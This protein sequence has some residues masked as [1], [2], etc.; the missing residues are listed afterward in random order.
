MEVAEAIHKMYIGGISDDRGRLYTL[1]IDDIIAC[2][3]SVKESNQ[4]Y[5]IDMAD[6]TGYN[7]G[8]NKAF[9]QGVISSI[10][11]VLYCFSYPKEEL[12]FG[13]SSLNHSK[14]THSPRELFEFWKEC[15]GNRCFH[16]KEITAISENES[17]KEINR[18]TCYLNSWSCF[19]SERS[20]P[21]RSI[22]DLPDFED[23]PISKMK[24]K[25]PCLKDIFESLL[26]RMDFL[27][28]GL[29]FSNCKD[30]TDQ[31]RCAIDNCFEEYLKQMNL[32]NK[33]IRH[34]SENPVSSSM[35]EDVVTFLIKSDFSSIEKAKSS[36]DKLK[37]S[38]DF[39]FI[40]VDTVKKTV[41][42][43]K[44]KET[45]HPII[46]KTRKLM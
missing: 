26:F 38:F 42:K 2:A 5:F 24:A 22:D 20:Y 15:F 27:K 44:N 18:K 32:I 23:D 11:G 12:I 14:K 19:D 6:S 34:F 28:G 29:I 40:N 16:S 39:Q 1:W 4:I 31:S 17:F 36:S 30:C 7:R 13:K 35:V 9:I 37:N 25:I 43:N 8:Y 33:N 41:L 46:V 10:A 45:E 3:V 21:F